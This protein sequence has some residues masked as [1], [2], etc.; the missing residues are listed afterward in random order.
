MQEPME[1][2]HSIM[3]QS[4]VLIKRCSYYCPVGVRFLS[5]HCGMFLYIH[6]M[7]SVKFRHFF[8]TNVVVALQLIH[9]LLMMIR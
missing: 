9:W 7:N 8:L 4:V 1:V 6:V 2:I 3:L 5:S